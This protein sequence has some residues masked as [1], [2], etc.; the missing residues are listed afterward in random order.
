[1]RSGSP[2]VTISGLPGLRAASPLQSASAGAGDQ[3]TQKD[4]GSGPEALP[5][6][7]PSSQIDISI[8]SEPRG[9]GRGSTAAAGG[10]EIRSQKGLV[11]GGREETPGLPFLESS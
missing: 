2:D 10:V 4:P 11:T 3:W 8:L 1:M 7:R 6:C 5:C 9:P